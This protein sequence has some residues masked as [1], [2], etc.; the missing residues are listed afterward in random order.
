MKRITPTQGLTLFFLIGLVIL[1]LLF[2]GRIPL[3]HSL[4]FRY[5][6]LIR[7][8][9]CPEMVMASKSDGKDGDIHLPF[10]SHPVCHPDL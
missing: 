7:S 5:F 8:S 3:W 6:G 1:T 4:L 9:L 10:F 2:H